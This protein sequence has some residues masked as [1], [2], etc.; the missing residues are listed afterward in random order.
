[1][2]YHNVLSPIFSHS[3]FFVVSLQQIPDSHGVCSVSGRDREQCAPHVP[4]R[5]RRNHYARFVRC[6]RKNGRMQES[7]FYRKA[8]ITRFVSDNLKSRKF[9]KS[10]QGRVTVD[11]HQG[12]FI[13]YRYMPISSGIVPSEDYVGYICS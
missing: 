5:P 3:Q 13:E 1:M 6:R 4:W 12:V 11:A 9:P 10:S 2:L 7:L 8:F